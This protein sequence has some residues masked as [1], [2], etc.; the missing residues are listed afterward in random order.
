MPAPLEV[1]TNRTDHQSMRIG[2]CH[3]HPSG[4]VN[5]VSPGGSS[6]SCPWLPD[7][8]RVKKHRG[9]PRL[10]PLRS[11]RLVTILQQSPDRCLPWLERPSRPP[12]SST[13]LLPASYS[14]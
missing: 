10:R 7:E 12:C 8:R 2:N 14:S 5:P 13:Q 4:L 1:A 6:C 9:R 3:F 11:Q